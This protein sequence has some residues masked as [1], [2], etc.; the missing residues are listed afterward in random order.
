MD[1]SNGDYI[2]IGKYME[3][4]TI[5]Y[6]GISASDLDCNEEMHKYLQIIKKADGRFVPAK[7]TKKTGSL[8]LIIE[9]EYI[10]WDNETELYPFVFE[11][12][13]NWS[14]TA[15]VSPPEGF[16]SDYD[17][18]S[19]DVNTEVDAL[20]FHIT[21]IGSD[22]VPTEMTYEI[23]H[24]GKKEKIKTKIGVAM[25]KKLAKKKGLEKKENREKKGFKEL[26]VFE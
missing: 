20:Q 22:W 13:G 8:L 6:L 7:Y 14:V 3:G 18:L 23:T 16:V 9:P 19:E 1:V 5:I 21:D 26:K 24:K 25:S 15:T 4:S 11:G 10:L 2:V 12:L 17:V